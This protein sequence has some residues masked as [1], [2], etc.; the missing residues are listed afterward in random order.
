MSM[1]QKFAKKSKR[2]VHSTESFQLPNAVSESDVDVENF[3]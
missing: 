1:R 3:I 2:I